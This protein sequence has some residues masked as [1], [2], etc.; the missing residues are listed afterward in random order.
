GELRKRAILVTRISEKAGG[1]SPIRFG[2]KVKDKAMAVFTRQFST[3][4]D[5]GLPLVQCL[6]ILAA[7]SESKTLRAVTADVGKNVE[8]GATL[9]EALRKHPRTFNDLFVNMVDVGE[10]GGILDVI[11]QRLAAYIEK[12]AALKRRVK[13]ALVY[14]AAIISVAVLVIVFMLTF[15]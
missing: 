12:S 11:F 4:I 2:G 1:R 10:A 9:A 8:T 14:P 15:V 7:Q 13:G 6:H 5:A 3:M